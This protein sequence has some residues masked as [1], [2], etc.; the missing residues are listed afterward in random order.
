MHHGSRLRQLSRGANH[1]KALLRNQAT[2]LVHEERI[3]TTVAKAKELKRYADKLVTMAKKGDE[4]GV[5]GVLFTEYGVQ[6][7]LGE[8]RQRFASRE[9]GYTRMFKIGQRRGD[10]AEMAVIELV[11]RMGELKIS[12]RHREAFRAESSSSS[13]SST[14]EALRAAVRGMNVSTR[15]GAW[16]LPTTKFS[17]SSSK[18]SKSSSSSSSGREEVQEVEAGTMTTSV[19]R[20]TR[21]SN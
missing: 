21:A 16:G 11:D 6:K 19:P 7:A 1:R 20:T 2:S 3:V 9:G 15:R 18:S 17:S 12:R 4:G 10:A 13:S 8:L 14:S 5:R